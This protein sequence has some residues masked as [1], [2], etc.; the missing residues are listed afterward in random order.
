MYYAVE[1]RF[2]LAMRF[3]HRTVEQ[4]WLPYSA[5]PET[6]DT[7][8]RWAGKAMGLVTSLRSRIASHQDSRRKLYIISRTS[9]TVFSVI[10][11]WASGRE[12]WGYWTG[13]R[14]L[15][16]VNWIC[17]V[18]KICLSR[19][20]LKE[21]HCSEIN[22]DYVPNKWPQPCGKFAGLTNLW[23]YWWTLMTSVHKE[24][25][26]ER[27]LSLVSI[28]NNLGTDSWINQ[29]K[30]RKAFTHKGKKP[31]K[32]PKNSLRINGQYTLKIINDQNVT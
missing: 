1:Y 11:P 2:C 9:W 20:P 26:G 24:K 7:R 25:R 17:H 30:E 10:T 13:S 32:Q 5:Q 12:N 31:P 21:D 14:S 16:P 8:N 15:V 3:G 27:R 29:I 4:K 22:S 18:M 6:G 23:R 28:V 19:P